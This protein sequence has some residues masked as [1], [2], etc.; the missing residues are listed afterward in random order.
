MG[1]YDTRY[2]ILALNIYLREGKYDKAIE[3]VRKYNLDDNY[4]L[5]IYLFKG[6]Y[7]NA[8]NVALKLYEKTSNPKYLIKYCEYLYSDHPTK[9]EIMDI[10]NKLRFLVKLYPSA[11]LY[12][13][14]GYVLIDNDLDVKEGL[15]Y[16]QKAVEI[17]PQSQEY[18]DSLAWGYY[19]LGK[20]K[21]A[22]EIIKYIKT[23]DEEI[24]KH[25]KLIE[26]CLKERDDSS[27]NN[28]KN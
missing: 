11:R 3:I 18:I 15:E 6:D 28:R 20:C 26:K 4:L 14:L 16:V 2:Y 24:L 10:V 9:E 7:R 25:K 19:K 23:D 17:N 5:T 12:N 27:K 8:A 21:E 1:I 13:F 22:Y